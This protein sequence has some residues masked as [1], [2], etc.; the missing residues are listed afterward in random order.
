MSVILNIALKY[1]ENHPD[2]I[3]KLLAAAID[4]LISHIEKK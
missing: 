3:E 1:L 4:A 2:Q